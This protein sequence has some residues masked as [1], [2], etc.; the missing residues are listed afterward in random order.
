MRALL[1]DLPQGDGA[2]AEAV[3]AREAEL[4][5][6]RGAL[7]RLEELAAWL[8]RWQGRPTP[9]LERTRVAVF[10]GNHGVAAR[11]VSAYPASVT[12]QM[13]ANFERGGAAVCQLARAA[14][15]ELHV[16]ALELDAPAGDVTREDALDDDGFARAAAAGAAAVPAGL[17]LLAIGE[18]G[19]ANT[20]VAAAL[21]AKFL[22]GTGRDWVGRGTGVD[23]EGLA[24]KAAAVDAALAR[25]GDAADPLDVLRRLGGRELVAM[26]AAI[27]A[28]RHRR[29]P[30]LIDGFVASAAALPLVRARGD[31]LDHCRLAHLSAEIGHRRLAEALGLE[32]LLALGMRLGEASGAALAIPLVRA[33][34]ACHT[35]MAT[36]AE[37]AV[38]DRLP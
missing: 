33:A 34:V 32:P 37:A 14:G 24:R 20:T 6:P 21:A 36:F 2:A 15:A 25:H 5:K 29:V 4:T 28:A 27:T 38:D 23:D 13:V 17:D 11:G 30:V 19:I 3:A 31:A 12:A 18:M 1:A 26:A 22:G 35:G 10:A 8:A 7:G 9:R 16:D